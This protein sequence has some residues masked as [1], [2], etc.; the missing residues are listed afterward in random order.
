MGETLREHNNKLEEVFAQIRKYNLKIEPDKCK[1]LKTE[2][3]YLDVR[4][5]W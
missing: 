4:L 1:F 2:L 5:V 3:P